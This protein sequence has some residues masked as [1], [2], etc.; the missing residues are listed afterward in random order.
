M[1]KFTRSAPWLRQL[2]TPSQTKSSNPGSLSED[3]SLVQVY[4]G[5]GFN[6]LSSA[7][8]AVRVDSTPAGAT[9]TTDILTA[10]PE[11][12]VRVFSVSINEEGASTTPDCIIR[13]R[14]AA[15][16]TPAVSGLLA[17]LGNGVVPPDFISN[18]VLPPGAVLEGLHFNGGAGTVIRY[19]AYF[20][21]MPVGAVPA[22]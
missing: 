10:G 3:V 18:L 5:G 17:V 2:F 13:V 20:N 8:W 9:D 6:F 11:E 1:N 22:I 14:V 4:D 19:R 15:T 16:A 21:R 7:M 12:L